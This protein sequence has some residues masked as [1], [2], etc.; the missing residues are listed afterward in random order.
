MQSFQRKIYFTVMYC[1]LGDKVVYDF[2]L[3]LYTYYSRQHNNGIV[4]HHDIAF[5]HTHT[6]THIA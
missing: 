3:Y 1:V 6:H 4:F 5:V 2:S